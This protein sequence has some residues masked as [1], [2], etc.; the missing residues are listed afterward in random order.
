[1]FTDSPVS[2]ATSL[3]PLSFVVC[4]TAFKQ[5]YEDWLRHKADKLTNSRLLPLVSNEDKLI[6]I[7]S[8]DIRLGK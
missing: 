4:V 7:Q 1:M 8:R 3:I 6:K 2:P 5:A